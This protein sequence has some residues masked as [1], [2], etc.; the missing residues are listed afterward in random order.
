[1]DRIRHFGASLRAQFESM[2]QRERR[3]ALAFLALVVVLFTVMT[4]VALRRVVADEA[5]RVRVARDSLV[6]VQAMTTELQSLQQRIEVAEQRMG[7]FHANQMNTYLEGWAKRAGVVDTLSVKPGQATEAGTFQSVPYQVSIA[8]ADLGSLLEFLYAME[9]S[10]YPIRVRTARVRAE[11][12][13]EART[14]RADFE[15]VAYSKE[16]G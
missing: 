10:P 15:V 11:G 14:L 16:Q 3:I 12:R 1:M 2:G 7:A 6:E 8:K 5:S 9:T 13:P 4:T